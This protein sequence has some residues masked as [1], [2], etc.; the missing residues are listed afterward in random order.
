MKEVLNFIKWQWAK[1]SVS[2]KLWLLGCVFLGAA[3]GEPD[4]DISLI[5]AAIGSFIWIGILLHMI[6]WEGTKTQWA[7]Y[8]KEKAQLFDTIDQGR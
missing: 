1:W 7:R 8:K 6:V 3:I 2:N 4:K 5:L